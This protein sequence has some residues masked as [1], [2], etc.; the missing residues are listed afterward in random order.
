MSQRRER[1][2]K[3]D[4]T[5][6]DDRRKLAKQQRPEWKPDPGYDP[7]APTVRKLRL[8]WPARCEAC[9]LRIGKGDLAVMVNRTDDKT[10]YVHALC[11]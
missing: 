9:E 11:A 7:T 4:W 2:P 8:K 6:N 10:G 1:R 3:R 5:R